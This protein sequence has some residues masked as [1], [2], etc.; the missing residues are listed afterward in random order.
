MDDHNVIDLAGRAGRGI[1]DDGV[2]WICCIR[3]PGIRP[4]YWCGREPGDYA[5][6]CVAVK[7]A[8]AGRRDGMPDVLQFDAR[9]A[10][11]GA[12][13]TQVDGHRNLKMSDSPATQSPRPGK[14]R[15][16]SNATSRDLMGRSERG[17]VQ[18]ERHAGL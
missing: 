8:R 4:G 5:G 13:E 18:V 12:G 10:R 14:K 9:A 7:R 11:A 3:I 17:E 2:G 15:L 6:V 1:L 16:W